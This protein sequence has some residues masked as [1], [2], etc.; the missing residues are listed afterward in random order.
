VFIFD[1]VLLVLAA[2]RITRF[3]LID[4][5][6]RRNK[7]SEKYVEGLLSC[8]FCIGF[9]ISLVGVATLY[10]A[11]GPGQAAL[12]WRALAGVWALSYLVGHGVNRLDYS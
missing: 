11:G 10:A 3:V 2:L 7:K 12:W 9:W 4:S 6:G 1:I 5:L 8:P